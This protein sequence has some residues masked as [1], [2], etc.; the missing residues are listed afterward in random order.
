MSYEKEMQRQ[1]KEMNESVSGF[2]MQ[3]IC[4]YCG[5]ESTL[6]AVNMTALAQAYQLSYDNHRMLCKKP[7][8]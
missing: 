2:K 8:K 5:H 6:G 1:I 3:W 7:Q 4:K